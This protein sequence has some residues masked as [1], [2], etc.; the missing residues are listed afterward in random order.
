MRE[1]R[2]AA[3]SRR[4]RLELG[5]RAPEEPS[6]RLDRAADGGIALLVQRSRTLD[7]VVRGLGA[8]AEERA[9][10]RRVAGAY[11]DFPVERDV[12]ELFEPEAVLL[13]EVD[14]EAV[15]AGRDRPAHR[16]LLPKRRAR[17]DG[18]LERRALAVP[19]DR[20]AA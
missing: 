20:V 17:L 16:Q 18:P 1:A 6:L 10:S 9:R 11:L 8:V 15:A 12:A 2:M 5:R 4:V 19:H 13:D 14:R 3:A 7:P